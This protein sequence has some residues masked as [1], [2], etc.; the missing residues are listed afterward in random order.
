MKNFLAA[1]L[2]LA[3]FSLASLAIAPTYYQNTDKK[4]PPIVAK[5]DG[6]SILLID[7]LLDTSDVVYS[8]PI[9][10]MNI[11]VISKDTG[12]TWASNVMVWEAGSAMVSCYDNS[13]SAAVT[14]SVIV[15]GQ[16][17]KSQYAGDN[18]D[19]NGVGDRGAKSDVWASLGSAY[20]LADASAAGALVEATATVT[21]TSHMDR[22][23][24]MKLTNATTAI[25]NR[26]RCKVYWN[27]KPVLR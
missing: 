19:P 6:A 2:A 8:R 17:Q 26:A 7:V 12:A 5:N 24:R 16:M 15:T 3:S 1:I 23:I 20:T 21:L 11:P 18:I 4:S 25:K 22:Y 27:R 9:D 14:D 13:D 10:L